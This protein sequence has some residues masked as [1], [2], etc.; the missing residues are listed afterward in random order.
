[1]LI[2][3][4][5]S[6]IKFATNCVK[7]TKA[8]NVISKTLKYASIIGGIAVAGYTAF[9]AGKDIYQGVKN[10][11]LTLGRVIA[12]VLSIGISAAGIGFGLKELGSNIKDDFGIDLKENFK[13]FLHDNRGFV[14]LDATI[15]GSKGGSDVKPDYYVTPDGVAFKN[16]I[17]DNY[18][19]NPYRNGSYGV[20]DEN[21][22]FT[23]KLRIDPATPIGK[24]GPSY[25]HYHIDGGKEHFSPRPNDDNP[26]EF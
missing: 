15:G 24:K 2:G 18:V 9:T 13:E 8:A 5:V 21:G 4:M 12:D 11:D 1:P 16:G 14:D 6:G 23:E 17:P 25:S 22:K 10:H 7:L 20:F 3:N 19:E 26:L